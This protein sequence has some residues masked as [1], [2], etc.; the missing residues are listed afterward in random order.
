MPAYP[1]F[2]LMIAA[3]PFLVP[4]V[5]RRWT[6]E[7]PPS[8][9]PFLSARARTTA[10]VAAVL[11]TAVVPMAAWAVA[12]P[13]R[14]GPPVLRAAILQQPPIPLGVDIGLRARRTAKSV[15]LTWRAQHPAG[16]PVFYTIFRRQAGTTLYSCNPGSAAQYCAL[17]LTNLGTTH[18]TT[19]SDPKPLAGS[20]SYYVGVTA[21]WLIDRT[22]GDVYV[23][24][25]GAQAP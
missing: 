15:T 2:A 19:W 8:T 25:S 16:G 21:N 13:I 14:S 10:L 5:A 24:S 20:A 3:L 1:A 9:R 23:L 4:G 17:T 7:P 12:K 6:G 22:Q 18:A 11:G